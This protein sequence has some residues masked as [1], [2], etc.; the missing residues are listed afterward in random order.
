LWKLGQPEDRSGNWLKRLTNM[1]AVAVVSPLLAPVLIFVF[2]PVYRKLKI[3]TSYEYIG[4]R[5]GHLF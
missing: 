4:I 3:T 5:F 1:L 2:Y